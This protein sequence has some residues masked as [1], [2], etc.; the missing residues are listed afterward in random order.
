M[1]FSL[2][3]L[4]A[5][6]FMT[7]LFLIWMHFILWLFLFFSSGVFLRARQARPRKKGIGGHWEAQLWAPPEITSTVLF[8]NNL[9]C[10][11]DSGRWSSS[12]I[13]TEILRTRS[14]C[15]WC[16]RRSSSFRSLLF[17]TWSRGWGRLWDAFAILWGILLLRD[18][19]PQLTRLE[20]SHLAGTN[21]FNNCW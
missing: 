17:S 1:T 12:A 14:P 7:F 15:P 18:S 4:D 21:S 2:F 3:N 9:D 11:C 8:L 5:F 10:C 20:E 16:G 6:Y 13:P 19:T